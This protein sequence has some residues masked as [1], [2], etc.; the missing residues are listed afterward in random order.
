LPA[1]STVSPGW[2]DPLIGTFD[3]TPVKTICA[4]SEADENAAPH[5]S[6]ATIAVLRFH[7]L[8]TR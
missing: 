3:C 1:A 7:L 2:T 4:S 6:N 8:K 5:T